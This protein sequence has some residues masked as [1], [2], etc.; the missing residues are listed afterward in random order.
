M[1]MQYAIVARVCMTV[2]LLPTAT[3]DSTVQAAP[4]SSSVSR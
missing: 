2:S 3:F 4:T 1:E